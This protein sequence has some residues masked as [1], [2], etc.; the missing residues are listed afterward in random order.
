MDCCC[1]CIWFA[2]RS[3]YLL[4]RRVPESGV[5]VVAT[6][7]WI[8]HGGGRATLYTNPLMRRRSRLFVVFSPFLAGLDYE[9]HVL[10]FFFNEEDFYMHALF[11]A[12]LKLMAE[13]WPV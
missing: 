2:T 13:R 5:Y 3:Q 12:T 7:R 6:R 9:D 11:P 8:S 4:F 10:L 1:F